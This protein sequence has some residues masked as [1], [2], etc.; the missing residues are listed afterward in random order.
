MSILKDRILAASNRDPEAARKNATARALLADQA[1]DTPALISSAEDVIAI[2]KEWLDQSIEDTAAMSTL[3]G[4]TEA[5]LNDLRAKCRQPDRH[6][7]GSKEWPRAALQNTV[8]GTIAQRMIE[9]TFYGLDG[10]GGVAGDLS[11]KYGGNYRL[12]SYEF[13]SDVAHVSQVESIAGG[14]Q[15]GNQ[16]GRTKVRLAQMPERVVVH[17]EMVEVSGAPVLKYD[18]NTWPKDS[19]GDQTFNLVMPADMMEAQREVAEA[20]KAAAATNADTQRTLRAIVAATSP[21]PPEH[22]LAATK[23]NPA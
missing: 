13:D 23:K 19:D 20:L 15:T 4:D 1:D 8:D 21:T 12:A 9:A 11:G 22:V 6:L 16:F 3:D 2:W 5:R 14:A 7:V 17:Y 18:I 10:V